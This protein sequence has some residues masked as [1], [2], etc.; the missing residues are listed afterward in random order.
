MEKSE[1]PDLRFIA[2]VRKFGNSFHIIIP[3]LQAESLKTD[4]VRIEIYQLK[5]GEQHGKTD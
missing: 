4:K 2:R 3:R 1:K 5:G